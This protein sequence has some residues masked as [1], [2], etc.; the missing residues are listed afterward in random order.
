MGVPYLAEVASTFLKK[1]E[2]IWF[3]LDMINLLQ[4]VFIFLVYVFTKNVW[5]SIQ[6]KTGSVFCLFCFKFIVILN[7]TYF[8]KDW[9]R[10]QLKV[11][12]QKSH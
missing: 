4:G 9:H 2:N 6:Q 5:K 8:S 11:P 1:N 3:I 12:L 7:Y 10:L